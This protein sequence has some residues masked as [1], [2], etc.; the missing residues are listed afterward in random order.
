MNRENELSRRLFN[1]AIRVIKY[2][3]TL[4]NSAEYSIIKYQLIKS[5]TSSGANYKEAQSVIQERILIIRLIL[6]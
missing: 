5:A 6:L 2:L 1:F 3:R 4:P